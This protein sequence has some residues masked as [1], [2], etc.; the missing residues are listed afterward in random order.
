[1]KNLPYYLNLAG[2]NQKE[3]A[4]ALGVTKSTVSLWISGSNYPRTDT[5][6]RIATVLGCT[7]EDLIQKNTEAE[8]NEISEYQ[9]TLFS[10][11]KTATPEALKAAI[12]V[13]QSLEESN[14]D[15]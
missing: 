15:I 7:M 8:R 11:S 1:M 6:Q 3:L 5:I 14:R 13:L 4:E 2:M 10:L 9:K 12:A